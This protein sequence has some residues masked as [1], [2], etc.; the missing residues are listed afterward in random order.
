MQSRYW[1]CRR[2][3]IR[4]AACSALL[5]L[6]G[7]FI[8]TQV[9]YPA[10]IILNEYNAVSS[11]NYLGGDDYR[12]E[13]DPIWE[14]IYFR[15]LPGLPDGRIQGNGGNWIELVV[16]ED[17]LDLR[18]WQIQWA[19]A[20]SNNTNGS[21]LWYGDAAVEQGI[22]TFSN[23]AV[24]SDLRASTI[25]TIS[26][27]DAIDVDTD[28][29]GGGDDRNKTDGLDP[30]EADTTINL[31]TDV[32]YDPFGG[33]WWI[34]VSTR[35]EQA[36]PE[37]LD[38]LVTSVTNNPNN[39]A[40]DFSVGSSR[41]EL[42]IYN[43]A[44]G[45]NPDFGPVGEDVVG[46]GGGG[47]NSEETAMVKVDPTANVGPGD[48]DD[49]GNDS[50]LSSFGQPNEWFDSAGQHFA[51]DFT[52]LRPTTITLTSAGSGP[53]HLPTTWDDG[54]LT[55]TSED[56]A[57]VVADHTVYVSSDGAAASSLTINGNA[58]GVVIVPNRTLTITRDVDVVG[59]SIA[60]ARGAKLDLGRDFT[61][62]RNTVF[63][64]DLDTS[65]Q[66]MV[67]AGRN[68]ALYQDTTLSMR[69]ETLS[70]PLGDLDAREWGPKPVTIIS[71]AGQLTGEFT[72]EPPTGHL[73]YGVFNE[74]LSYPPD[75][76]VLGLFQ[77]APGD[78][79]GDHFVAGS[80]IEAILAANK[81]GRSQADL[82]LSG[83]WPAT[84]PDGDFNADQ[85]VSGGDIQAILAANLFGQPD[86]Y[87]AADPAQPVDA[88]LALIV[89][90][91]GLL[92]DTGDV[93]INGYVLTSEAGIFTGQPADNLGIFQ[94]DT[95]TEISGNF[96]FALTGTH[97][98]GDVIGEEFS[99]VDLLGDVTLSYTVEGAS[100][101]YFA[102]IVVPEPGT[103]ALLASGGLGLMLALLRRRRTG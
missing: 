84:W 13:V 50:R 73:N 74:G 61:M 53:W 21:D 4:L 45:P 82:M 95:D 81:F 7:S 33:D 16:I 52:S 9:A 28:W 6:G 29:D 79:D 85:L 43:P 26:E 35:G 65:T 99:E 86:P 98:L 23:A 80:D 63:S 46:W 34:H 5:M 71:A 55:P 15:T 97:L 14:D 92:I 62:K 10:A 25:I 44:A 69:V 27:K 94:L 37:P 24:W 87:G 31:A 18:G 58:A 100:G 96:G 39:D 41:W 8:F 20:G 90:P 1:S 19:E 101:R 30:G 91:D 103:L 2:P 89:T 51:Q 22:V 70:G 48:F 47:V 36:R 66:T 64:F 72:T 60:F 17:H 59:H 75:A 102:S 88:N 77:G 54:T 3:W 76:V 67:E 93:S 83:D 12:D 78:T 38:R 56:E 32:S 11:G 57:V 40:G 42:Q 68:V 49:L